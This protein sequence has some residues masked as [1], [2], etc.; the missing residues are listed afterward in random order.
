MASVDTS[1]S[2][3]HSAEHTNRPPID[4]AEKAIMGNFVNP[5]PGAPVHPTD[6]GC[7]V[8]IG[9]STLD[10][11][12]ATDATNQYLV[13]GLDPVR[14]PLLEVGPRSSTK[15]SSACSRQM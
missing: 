15:S 3:K 8:L 10:V 7:L 12:A 6:A 11:E 14:G 5:N 9:P 4:V 2:P 13:P 1:T